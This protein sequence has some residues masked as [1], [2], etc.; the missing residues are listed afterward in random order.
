MIYSYLVQNIVEVFNNAEFCIRIQHLK[1][2]TT[3][4]RIKNNYYTDKEGQ[5]FFP[6]KRKN[7]ERRK[8]KLGLKKTKNKVIHQAILEKNQLM[9]EKSGRFICSEKNYSDLSKQIAGL[10]SI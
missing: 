5:I 3:F 7:K 4:E 10:N 2:P 1:K 6:G 8:E 9:P